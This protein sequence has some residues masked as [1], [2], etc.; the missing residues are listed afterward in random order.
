MTINEPLRQV[1]QSLVLLQ[2]KYKRKL[3]QLSE[4]FDN[5]CQV[6]ADKLKA[7]REQSDEIVNF[8]KES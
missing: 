4:E 6:L 5:D 1:E 7:V 3:A 2:S 8:D